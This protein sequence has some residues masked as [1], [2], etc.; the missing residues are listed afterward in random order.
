LF[1]QVN[2][3]LSRLWTIDL[4]DLVERGTFQELHGVVEDAIG[5]APVVED[6]H[7]VRMREHGGT[8]D[9]ALEAAQRSLAGPVGQQQLD[10]RRPAEH[11]VRGA[12]DHAHPAFPEL[13]LQRVLSE[14]PNV[15]DRL[16]QAVDHLRKCGRH[17]HGDAPDEGG[18]ERRRVGHVAH[19]ALG[20]DGGGRIIQR[21]I[22]G[23]ERDEDA[24]EQRHRHQRG[25]HQGA[26]RGGRDID[27]VHEQH[28]SD[29]AA[30]DHVW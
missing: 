10:R 12:V 11:R 4:D 19:L 26:P 6:G 28:V 22:P 16:A 17:G 13:L 9:L 18:G 5:R 15:V 8:L 3:A 24:A 7:G 27:R 30:H 2:D 1:Q 21:R 25:D 20:P 29:R 23:A 14:A